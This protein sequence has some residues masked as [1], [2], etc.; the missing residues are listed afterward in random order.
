MKSTH[1]Q[2]RPLNKA[3]ST[4]IDIWVAHGRD[5]ACFGLNAVS[6]ATAFDK[7]PEISGALFTLDLNGRFQSIS[8]RFSLILNRLKL[9]AGVNI[10]DLVWTSAPVQVWSVNDLNW[11]G[12]EVLFTGVASGQVDTKRR[13][14]SIDAEGSSDF[15]DTELLVLAFDGGG[16]L[17]GEPEARDRLKPAGFG[18]VQNLEP[19]FYD[20]TRSM[21]MLD[22]YNNLI[23]I[24]WVAEGLNRY[25]SYA[26]NFINEAALAAALDAAAVLP[27]QWAS[28]IADGVIGFGAPPVGIV[29]ASATF[30]T[31]LTGAVLKR[32]AQTHGGVPIGKIDTASFD[33][34]DVAMP[35]PVS[36][37]TSSQENIK[38]LFERMSRAVLATP[39]IDNLE[40]V[41]I[42]QPF[43]G[44][45]AATLDKS[46]NSKPRVINHRPSQNWTPT[47]RTVARAARPAVVL[48]RDQIN[49]EDDFNPRGT[50]K[51]TDTYRL[52]DTVFSADK[53]E[54]L[55]TST[56]PK[57]GSAAP[58]PV[59][60]ATSNANWENISPPA[61]AGNIRY[62]TGETLDDLKPGEVGATNDAN[63]DDPNILTI[64][65][66]V[67]ER[68]PK[69]DARDGTNGRYPTVRARAVAL[70]ISVVSVDAARANWIAYRDSIT[71]WS[72]TGVHSNITRTSWN[73]LDVLY[74]AALN[75]LDQ[76][77]SAEDA[78]R[79]TLDAN[80]NLVGDGANVANA[81]VANKLTSRG[82]TSAII[83][84]NS[85]RRSA[86]DG[87]YLCFVT[88]DPISGACFAEA[89]VSAGGVWTMLG[90]DPTATAGSY[91][92]Q[93]FHIEIRTGGTG[94]VF[95]NG[96][97]IDTLPVATAGT[98][99][100]IAYDGSRYQVF[101]DGVQVGTDYPT[102]AGKTHHAIFTAYNPVRY[103]G[104]NYG[105]YS[106]NSAETKFIVQTTAGPALRLIGGNT[107]KRDG[108]SD[109]DSQC[110]S[111]RG[112]TGGCFAELTATDNSCYFMV[113]L[114]S[115]PTTD[116]SYLSIDYAMYSGTDGNIYCYESGTGLGLL[117]ALTPGTT[118]RVLYDDNFIRYF[119]NGDEVR[120]VRTTSGRKFH[121]D[122]S[123]VQGAPLT[124]LR[125]GPVTPDAAS[126]DFLHD[127][128][129]Q[130][131]RGNTVF[132]RVN[133]PGTGWDT[134][135][136]SRQVQVGTAYVSGK[137]ATVNTFIGL[138]QPADS[139]TTYGAMQASFH[140]SGD[141]NWYTWNYGGSRINMG[142]SY[143]SV[144]FD[145]ST[146]FR[147]TYDGVKLRWYANNTLVDSADIA[148]GLS[149][150]ACVAVYGAGNRVENIQFGPY[151]D[152]AWASTGG[153]NK[154]EDNADVTSYITGSTT[155]TIE[156]DNN[157]TPISALLPK[158]TQFKL[159]KNGVDETT[160]ATWSSSTVL[161]GTVTQST[162]VAGVNSVTAM[163]SSTAKVRV[164][165][166]LGSAV[167]WMDV[168]IVKRLA[169]A[170][171]GG[172]G[173]GG[174]SA[175][176]PV[177]ATINVDGMQTV[178]NELI[179]NTGSAGTATLTGSVGF[180]VPETG[181]NRNVLAFWIWQ[182]WNG[183]AWVDEGTE[184][185][186]DPDC[187]VSRYFDAEFADWVY[188]IASGI[189]SV[190][191][192]VTGLTANAQVKFR[193]RARRVTGPGELVSLYTTSNIGGTGT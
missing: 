131:Q 108:G 177:S 142:A 20:N 151:T 66:K 58:L 24:Q 134:K 13:Y 156:C 168:D 174:T 186:S 153:A 98:A 178:S 81:L 96:S 103:S 118:C 170:E 147:I 72:N 62:G 162:N 163:S 171:T 60:P 77:I 68:N 4:R 46:G 70:G 63:L 16:G 133:A 115:D 82:S 105:P 190:G 120:S 188:T 184:V 180:S 173:S 28:C 10:E 176:V 21:A 94:G 69:E 27:G 144:T 155:I 169:P 78:K 149:Y 29:T 56:T 111:E 37:W 9:P 51:T 12:R 11:A 23:S 33:A 44:A 116:A 189:L 40:R 143:L 89:I 100:R 42:S 3:T 191:K 74:D 97:Q 101:L 8:A 49:F 157:G 83:E 87:D 52:G 90:L 17:G 140:R 25:S 145:D 193:L 161:S 41:A 166:T 19:V 95:S 164:T 43:G 88:G 127:G 124:N 84:G 18:V 117:G 2:I 160:N 167:R 80:G 158:T 92:D 61:T 1:V 152:N 85:I 119:I 129:L 106:I 71:N 122:S 99:V 175:T 182:R 48:R 172:S 76:A 148:S 32:M 31:S 141:G 135:S 53:A 6:W 36:F 39:V 67:N 159:M 132:K 112:I 154:P 139:G 5:P 45:S 165:A 181:G 54:W 187:N 22:G 64:N 146:E 14:V 47:A 38:A 50:F 75:L 114:N 59:W 79:A 30:G 128:N 123:V 136:V 35:R 65:E 138:K 7:A 26:G 55:Y 93:D 109:W 34:L 130:S 121:F 15:L 57:L 86:G 183:S 185:E 150:S 137:L 91:T 113:G 192:V 179:F 102:L 107:L 104:L 73:S 110:Y 125:F 126:V